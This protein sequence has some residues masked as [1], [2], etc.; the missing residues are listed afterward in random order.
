M[1][2]FSMGLGVYSLNKFGNEKLKAFESEAQA[3]MLSV[4]SKV[5]LENHLYF[6]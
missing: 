4:I 1:L 2:A 5:N 3:H 6:N